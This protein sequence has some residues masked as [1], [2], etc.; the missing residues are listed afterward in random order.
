VAVSRGENADY[1]RSL[2]AAAVID[3]TKGEVVEQVRAAYP[4][5][6]DALLDTF[7][8]ADGVSEVA[9]MVRR[10]GVVISPKRAADDEALGARGVRG[11]NVSRA[12]LSKLSDMND[13][14]QKN[15]LRPPETKTFTLDEAN[16]AVAEQAGGHVRGKLAITVD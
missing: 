4:D 16:D 9:G 11:A 8:D 14:F 12:S 7:H 10:G 5:G 1:A 13:L 6:V 2:G 15:A 3:Y